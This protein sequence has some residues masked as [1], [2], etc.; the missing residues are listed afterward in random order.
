[1]RTDDATTSASLTHQVEDEYRK[2]VTIDGV[3]QVLTIWYGPGACWTHLYLSDTYNDDIGARLVGPY[4]RM[5][6]VILYFQAIDNER[7]W[8]RERQWFERD[9][10]R[11][12]S[13]FGLKDDEPLPALFVVRASPV[14]CIQPYPHTTI[15]PHQTLGWHH[16][17]DLAHRRA[18]N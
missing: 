14:R 2:Q 1:M 12:R 9:V 16:S 15:R 3:P 5:P 11:I 8:E 4:V 10:T 17:I 7:Q 18:G 13:G 6:D